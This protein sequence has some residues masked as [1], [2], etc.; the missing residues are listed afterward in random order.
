MQL[1]DK[2]NQGSKLKICLVS[3]E[4]P[5]GP[6]VGGIGTQTYMK[7]HGLAEA[8]HEVYVI[9][10]GTDN[11]RHIYNEGTV[12]V[13][14]LPTNRMPTYTDIADWITHS[15]M[16]ASEL[17]RQHEIHQF[18]I[19]EIPEWGCEGY[20]HL[21]N[22]TEWNRIPT[23]IHL[24]GPLVMLANTIGWPQHDSEFYRVGI[25]MEGTC[26]R[27]ADAIYS[28]SSCSSD[29]CSREYGVKKQNIPRIHSGIDT[30]I[31]QPLDIAKDT[32][33]TII[34]VGKMVRNK[35]VHMLLDVALELS[36]EFPD[37]RLQMLGDGEKQVITELRT[38][39][40]ERGLSHLLNLPGRIPREDL[41]VYLS[42][43]HIFAAPSK[44]EGGPGFVY[45]EAM[46][47]GLPVI[48]CD[49]SGV[50]EIIRH[51]DNGLLVPSENVGAL[52]A[53]LHQLLL[54]SEQ[55]QSMGDRARQFVLENA[56]SE[57]CIKKIA[58][59]YE[60]VVARFRAQSRTLQTSDE[61][62]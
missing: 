41:P 3:Q 62:R 9:T 29:W 22:Q 4:Y 6:S 59:F 55:R 48:A 37:L 30:R 58:A 2:S 19:V 7:A 28:S 15:G 17:I 38:R 44:Y 47:C 50:A 45:L 10:R 49:G 25:H 13:T 14:R 43:S 26:L 34:F 20:I 12:V 31:F 32:Q 18:D 35:G 39:A 33:L 60:D 36:K 5:P 57:A 11:N 21:L 56:D 16:V 61:Q 40:D 8:G 1:L 53:A 23:V 52:K 42:R 54:S 24:H 46:A 27:L 51:G